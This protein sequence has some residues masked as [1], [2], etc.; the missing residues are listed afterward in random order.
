MSVLLRC[1]AT[2]VAAFAPGTAPVADS[3]HPSAKK[4]AAAG[5]TNLSQLLDD[6]LAALISRELE[7]RWLEAHPD[8]ELPA[9]VPV[10][11]SSVPWDE[12]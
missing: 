9:E 10:D 6:A 4:F 7:H 3:R 1:G 5:T 2:I 8:D 11:L 12:D